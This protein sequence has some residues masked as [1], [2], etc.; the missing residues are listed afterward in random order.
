[1]RAEPRH[2]L[3]YVLGS[4]LGAQAILFSIL[5]SYSWRP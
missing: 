3:I 5:G 4:I 2:A 1:M